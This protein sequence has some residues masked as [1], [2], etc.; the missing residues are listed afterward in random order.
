MAPTPRHAARPDWAPLLAAGPALVEFM[1]S[2]WVLLYSAE[3]WPLPVILAATFGA[4][5]AA[6]H[7]F[8][9]LE[10]DVPTPRQ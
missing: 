4:I 5:G 1:A 6:L 8:R 9:R 3:H 2:V 10:L 7:L